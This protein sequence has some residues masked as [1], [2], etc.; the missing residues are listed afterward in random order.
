MVDARGAIVLVNA[1]VERLFG[2]DREALYG[3]DVEILL[4]ARHREG[5][6]RFREAFRSNPSSRQMGA[7]RELSALR[8]DGTEFPVEIGLTPVA[9]EE[10]LFVIGSVVDITQRLNAERERQRLEEQLRQS[11]KMEALG[12]LA[13]GVAHDFNN[14]LAAIVGLAEL[15]GQAVVDR[16]RTVSDVQELLLSA[17]RGKELVDRILRFTR[18]Q[19]VRMD[20]LDLVDTVHQA[21]RLLRAS[22][23]PSIAIEFKMPAGTRL[24]RGDATSLEQV[25]M[26]LATNAAH[27]MP[28]GGTLQLLVDDWYVRDSVAR[29][30]PELREGPYVCVSVRDTGTGMDDATRSK[31]F[32]P[33]F[34]TKPPGEGSGLGLALVHGIMREHQGAVDLE[35]TLGQGTTVRILI[36]ALSGE[37][38]LTTQPHATPL[39]GR[40]ERLLFI[41]DEASLMAI[42]RRQLEG[43]G[44]VVEAFSDPVTALR[45][46]E[47]DPG[48][49]ALVVTD[50]L[51]PGMNGM[52][53]ARALR[54][55]RRDLPVV[56]LSGFIGDFTAAELESGGIRRILQKP[57]GLDGLSAAVQEA[58][59][60]E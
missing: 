26:N 30:R 55:H 41:D 27:A 21:T 28:G 3:R 47:L 24:V 48:R 53:F 4:P 37:L 40:G 29:A 9:T 58:L 13:G 43:L 50:Y 12:T 14:V 34:T 5:H 38:E 2:Y 11:Q 6:P 49:F 35:S 52:D 46:F 57:V 17:R 7:G 10:G 60:G 25:L 39:R 59:A 51:M 32:E 23:P 19:P 8:A 20:T 16:P 18:R 45:A 42:G 1:E 22:L 54:A 31:A 15:I 56:L 44:Y 33:F 36:P